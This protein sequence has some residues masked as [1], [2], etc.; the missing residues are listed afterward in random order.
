MTTGEKRPILFCITGKGAEYKRREDVLT[1]VPT[2]PQR[3]KPAIPCKEEIT[4]LSQ[5]TFFISLF[6][7]C[8]KLHRSSPAPGK[9]RD[10]KEYQE[11]KEQY[12]CDSCCRSHKVEESED[13]GN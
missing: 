7:R 4:D 13:S 6:V 11:D 10:Y 1:A 8:L 9:E 5:L 12:F 2:L 3:N